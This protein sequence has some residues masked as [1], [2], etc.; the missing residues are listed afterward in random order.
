MGL[1]SFLKRKGDKPAAGP[2]DPAP[3]PED[4][5]VLGIEG[6]QHLV[7]LV[8]NALAVNG[9]EVLSLRGG[10]IVALP[11]EKPDTDTTALYLD[12][13]VRSVAPEARENWPEMT[14]HFVAAMLMPPVLD[15][16]WETIVTQLVL[17]M[18]QP[19][20]LSQE[21][22]KQL[23]TREDIP[24]VLS[25]VAVD[26]PQAVDMLP[27]NAQYPDALTVY[28]Y[29]ASNMEM[30][31]REIERKSLSGGNTLFVIRHDVCAPALLIEPGLTLGYEHIPPLGLIIGIPCKGVAVAL[32]VMGVATVQGLGPFV[33]LVHNIFKEE[34]RPLT[35]NLY[36]WCEGKDLPDDWLPRD[37]FHVFPTTTTSDGRRTTLTLP[38]ALQ[39]ILEARG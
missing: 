16:P 14:A 2:P 34:S 3:R 27:R 18:A 35:P 13:L 9:A 10:E 21:I 29:A 39:A 5:A 17:T 8:C 15:A 33:Q 31:P 19:E 22:V 20:D 11:P 6:Y 4:V 28:R 23:Y 32:P 25:V 7:V 12:N 26:S 36:W 1:F 24:G 30:R 38:P 37:A